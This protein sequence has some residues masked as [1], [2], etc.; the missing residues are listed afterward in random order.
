MGAEIHEA[1]GYAIRPAEPGDTAGILALA[2]ACG[3]A[4]LSEAV[5]NWRY[6]DHP[7]G[8]RA[9]VAAQEAD[10]AVH[11]HF[12]AVP[13]RAHW[14][15]EEVRFARLADAMVHPEAAELFDPSLLLRTA[16][17]FFRAH[18]G[19][20]DDVLV[21]ANPSYPEFLFGH[22]H[23]RYEM[24]RTESVL[25]LPED[26]MDRALESLPNLDVEES[27]RAPLGTA[28]LYERARNDWGASVVRDEARMDWRYADHPEH[29][30]LLGSVP[31]SDGTTRGIA[32]LRRGAWTQPDR[33]ILVDWLCPPEDEQ[34]GLALARW[35]VSRAR[36][37]E[38]PYVGGWLPEWS[39][40]FDRLQRHGFLV[41]PS[42]AFT[43][44]R[45][46]HAGLDMDW[47]L[48]NWFYT[49]GDT[50]LV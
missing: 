9:W 33:T 16:W 37:S 10:G 39:P 5:W 12:G 1:E 24:V 50:D 7:G 6:R 14:N 36:A 41:G 30:Y 48:N 25:F 21:H 40:W 27:E 43:M 34:A 45:N 11:A 20:G 46:F 31:H 28:A 35:A 2:E 13:E 47:L 44:A 32:V 19:P 4:R 22:R 29:E 17:P 26:R 49:L 15:G 8:S 42:Q 18:G 3:N 38:S 23:L